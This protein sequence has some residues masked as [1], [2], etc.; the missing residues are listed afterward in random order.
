MLAAIHR[1]KLTLSLPSVLNKGPDRLRL[2]G[3]GRSRLRAVARAN[4]RLCATI[5]LGLPPFSFSRD[6]TV[7]MRLPPPL[8]CGD[9][10]L[11]LADQ[12]GRA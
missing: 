3:M 2:G 8:P 7:I 9:F 6:A 11:N 5:V 4:S 1:Q 12:V 10:V